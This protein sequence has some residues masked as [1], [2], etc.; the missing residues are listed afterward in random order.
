M[1][2]HNGKIFFFFY[3]DSS[4]LEIHPKS[5]EQAYLLILDEDLNNAGKLF[6]E[7]DSPRAIWGEVLV[8]VLQGF[9]KKYPT[10]FQIRNFYEIDLDLL[11][12]NKKVSYVEHL[13]G[14]LEMFSTLNQEVYKYAARVMYENKFYSAALKYMNISKEI[15]YNDAELHFMLAKYY[16]MV[17]DLENFY[18]YIGECLKLLPD[19]YPALKLQNKIE[20]KYF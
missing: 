9:L 3:E 1:L 19:Y 5:L 6:K 18:T 7:L 15:Y 4:E 17:N 20:G 8:S 11:I 12:K 16:L 2:T 14:A 10:Y 13:L